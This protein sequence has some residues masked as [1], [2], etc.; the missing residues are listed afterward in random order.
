MNWNELFRDQWVG[1]DRAAIVTS[2]FTWSGDEL[3]RRAGGAAAWLD[4]LGFERGSFVPCLVDESADAI[5]LAVGATLSGRIPAPL[6]TKMPAA[7]LAVALR[8]LGACLLIAEDRL[9]DLASEAAAL[10]GATVVVLGAV[11]LGPIVCI[12]VDEDSPALV[13]H[14]SGT[15]GAPKAIIPSHR[16]LAA[17]VGIYS[18]TMPIGSADR[19]CSASPFAHTAGITMVF[20]VLALGASVIPQDWFSIE[21]WRQAGQLGMTC[22]LLVPTMIDLLLDAGALADAQPRVLQYGASPIHPDTLA[23]ALRALPDTQFIQ[24][25]GQTEVSP[26]SCLTHQDHLLAMDGRPDLLR[27][28][29]RVAHGAELQVEHPDGDGIGELAIRS[30]HTFA[31]DVDGWRRTGDFGRIDDE[32]FIT[33]HGR[34]NDRIIR[35]GENIYPVEIEQAL[36]GH[37][38]IREAAVVGIADRRWGEIVKAVVVAEDAAEPPPIAELQQ[39]VRDRLAHFK[40]PAIVEFVVELPRNSGGKVI[41]RQLRAT[42][43]KPEPLASLEQ[44]AQAFHTWLAAHHAELSVHRVDCLGDL[45][46]ALLADR[47]I[48]Q[49]LWDA[50]WMRLGWPVDVGGLGGS[51]AHRAIVMDALATAGYAVPAFYGPVEIIAPMLI[52][53]APHLATAHVAAG[54]RGDEVWCQGFSEPDAGSDL[55]SLR[56]RAVEVDGGYVITGQKMWSS[57]GQV[58]QW[59]CLLARTGEQGSG[60]RGLTMFWVDMHAAGV[61]VVPTRCESGRAETAEIFL[62]E[63]FVPTSH[64]IGSVGEGWSVV[65]YLLQ[66]ERGAYAWERQADLHSQLQ[67]LVAHPTFPANA[68]TLVGEAY[69]SL[70]ALRSQAAPTLMTL[71]GGT[72]L[73]P[74]ISIDKLLMSAAEQK[75]S[76]V[77]RQLLWPMLELDDTDE[78]V[79]WR[80]RW[81]YSRIT[82]IYGGAAEVQRDLVAERLLGLPRVR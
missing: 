42:D 22:G 65:M 26:I 36:I 17:R 20:T 10:A 78:A 73:G 4:A 60:Y 45:S 56:T 19:Y 28:V 15:T 9:S 82:T 7:D 67:G 59:C 76:D 48:M 32:G 38:G 31:A 47:P 41:R 69:L 37:Q 8:G 46:D 35:G 2:D 6:G 13:I 62:D 66:F 3:A 18:A 33:L 51:S 52:R 54:A 27:T 14:T 40:V 55:G 24:I 58:S 43:P 68:A 57:N 50:G 75:I 71:A 21:K 11:P 53:Y 29:G 81:A 34:T 23:A 5:A 63:V 80:R 30:P 61:S 64:L 12:D 74:E 72:D 1:S 77:A 79:L 70:F 49:R 16:Q 39:H 44:T 25:F